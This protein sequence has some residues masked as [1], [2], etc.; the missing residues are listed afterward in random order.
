[1]LEETGVER[2]KPTPLTVELG[3]SSTPAAAAIR[4]AIDHQIPSTLHLPSFLA[5][6]AYAE[7]RDHAA[8]NYISFDPDHLGLFS[9]CQATPSKQESFITCMQG[10]AAMKAP[11]TRIYDTRALLAGG[12]RG[13]RWWWTW[14]VG[15]GGT[16][17]GCWR[18]IQMQKRGSWCCRICRM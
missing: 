9:R 2:Y 17:H 13:P 3:D 11:W 14:A 12:N 5:S 18:C 4:G 10:V 6:T 1:M 8:T 7:P 16:C 15:M